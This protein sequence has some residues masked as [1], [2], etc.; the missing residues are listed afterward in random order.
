MS[1]ADAAPSWTR[2]QLQERVS[3]APFN[4]WLGLELVAWD[5]RGVTLRLRNRR[6]LSGQVA[7]RALHGGI[8][9]ALIDVG[10]S[11]AVIAQTGESIFTVDMR[12][13]Y[14][15]PATDDEFTVRGEVVR[16]GRTLAT[17]ETQVIA[18]DGKV[19]ASGRAVLQH[20]RQLA[21]DSRPS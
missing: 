1:M 15:R 4:S 14:L 11:M 2:E 18:A 13:D 19:V 5:E 20:V 7:L 21:G 9:A 10:C 17:A 6:E 12:V 3:R 16:L 8:I